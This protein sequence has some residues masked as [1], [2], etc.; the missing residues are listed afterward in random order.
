MAR[1]LTPEELLRRNRAAAQKAAEEVGVA[2]LKKLLERSAADLAARL[3]KAEGL[4]GAGKDSFTAVQ[5]RAVL[6]Q[7]QDVLRALKPG[8]KGVLVDQAIRAS[9]VQTASVLRYLADAEKHFT[10]VAAPLPISDAAVYDHVR[11]GAESSVLRRILSDPAN[12]AQP[13]VLDRYGEQVIGDFEASLAQRVLAKKPWAEVRDD[14]VKS[15]PFLQKAPAHWAERIVRTES[16]AASNRSSLE[17]I[18]V[19]ETALGDVVK[20][21]SATFDNRTAADSYAV[22]GQIRRPEEPFQD[23]RHSYMHPPNRPNDREVVVPHRLSWPIPKG[24]LPK[25]DAEVASAWVREG[26]KGSPPARPKYST[27]DVKLF[28]GGAGP[29]PGGKGAAAPP[30]APVAPP[31]APPPPPAAPAPVRRSRVVEPEARAIPEPS[32]IPRFVDA[33]GQH[34]PLGGTVRAGVE[35]LYGLT[36]DKDGGVRLRSLL[37]GGAPTV[38][39]SEPYADVLKQL[40]TLEQAVAKLG[41][42]KTVE[43][44]NLHR[45]VFETHTVDREVTARFA[46]LPAT[47][48]PTVI[49]HGG[50]YF[51]RDGAE[52]IAAQQALQV[53]RKMKASVEVTVIDLDREQRP[54]R[55]TQEWAVSQ[56]HLYDQMGKGMH[57]APEEQ[58][59][60]RG[61][62]RELIR[63]HGIASRDDEPDEKQVTFDH[64]A[65]ELRVVVMPSAYGMH[66]WAG[67]MYIAPETA[68]AAA[69]A[70]N[71]IAKEG[72]AFKNRPIQVQNAI[73]P[74]LNTFI[75]E[76]IHGASSAK[77]TSYVGAGI[78]MEEAAT[79]IL[80]RKVTRELV[81][82]TGATGKVALA[83]PERKPNGEYRVELG[84]AAP[85]FGSYNHHISKV[86]R[87]TG[88][89][90]G[91]DGVHEKIEQ[92]LLKTRSSAQTGRWRTPREQIAAYVDA[93]GLKGTKRTDLIEALLDVLARP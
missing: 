57:L 25:S 12:P 83:L 39:T 15:S 59:A 18:K 26:R 93:L 53:G 66:D 42:R 46:A 4:K 24:L 85:Y 29:A 76:E 32:G 8:M 9:K 61:N 80:A 2:R 6:G 56:T 14:L 44:E 20:I 74:R 37:P 62:V 23:W 1:P 52:M 87:E 21:I 28:G 10:G 5:A 63:G 78:G 73:L 72:Q 30:A 58:A 43:P 7:V 88:N 60:V 89:V 34:L 84:D 22:H 64:V 51:V 91:H 36:A 70:M 69:V 33:D 13:G 77:D 55:P 17:A 82:H 90:I 47:A 41:R 40:G 79:E 71:A 75:H 65:D 81:G 49:K 50:K 27:V 45:L 35:H 92:A 54:A 48:T 68:K 19:A 16:M 31:P 11:Q 86:L 3:A 67:R 38:D